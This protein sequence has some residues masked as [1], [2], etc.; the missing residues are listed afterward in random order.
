MESLAEFPAET[1][2]DVSG[3]L[4]LGQLTKQVSWGGHSFLLRTLRVH[5]ELAIG[6][7]TRK[8]EQTFTLGKA[9]AAATVGA[10]LMEVDGT[11][12]AAALGP[13]AESN[14]DHRFNKVQEYFWPVIER[15]YEE[16]LELQD[17]QLK[18]FDALQSKS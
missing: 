2:Q 11:E 16:Y 1:V 9:V 14:I 13:D 5:E 10:A 8:H 12:F 4:Y 7:V 18:A 17:Q 15:L 3:L 6:L